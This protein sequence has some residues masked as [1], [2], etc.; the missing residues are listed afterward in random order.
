MTQMDRRGSQYPPGKTAA[1]P[2][3]GSPHYWPRHLASL[4]LGT[5]GPEGGVAFPVRQSSRAPIAIKDAEGRRANWRTLSQLVHGGVPGSVVH[6]AVIAPVTARH[7]HPQACVD[8][9]VLLV[10][11]ERDQSQLPSSWKRVP[12]RGLLRGRFHTGRRAQWPRGH[13][14]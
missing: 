10:S 12:A 1:Q 8:G 2:P 6:Q 14:D 3:G 5:G 11:V 13:P 4:M 7:L 9:Q